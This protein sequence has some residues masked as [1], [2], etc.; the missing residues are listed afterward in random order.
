MVNL[1]YSHRNPPTTEADAFRPRQIAERS[2]A[3]DSSEV[4]G[5][6]RDGGGVEVNRSGDGAIVQLRM[7][8][9]RTLHPGPQRRLAEVRELADERVAVRIERFANGGAHPSSQIWQLFDRDGHLEASLQCTPDGKFA[10]VTNYRT[11]QTCRLI[12][13][14]F[15]ELETVETWRI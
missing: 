8:R 11:R 4:S 7:G 9:G 15:N 12:R 1:Q 13:N 14:R 2:K 5:S 6:R 10:L 3:C